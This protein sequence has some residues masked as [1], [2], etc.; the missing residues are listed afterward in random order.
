MPATVVEEPLGVA[1]VFSDGSRA[2]FGL[3]SLPAP[4]LARDLLV[5]LVELIHPHGSVD[6][7]GSVQH[8]VRAIRHMVRVVAGRGFAG[9]AG[10]LRRATLVE[11]W[12]GASGGK[13][14]C[15]RR[16]LH[17][18]DQ[19]TGGLAAPARELVAGRAYNPQPYRRALPPYPEAE[20]ARLTRTCQS[21][22]DAAF[23]AHR[24]ALADAATG[25]D[26]R[27]GGWSLRNLRWLLARTGP[28]STRALAQ[29]LGCSMQAIRERDGF[30]QAGAE[31]FPNL[32]NEDRAALRIEFFDETIEAIH[33]IDAI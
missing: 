23:A 15:T 18:F 20:W 24:D 7:A 13:E 8:Y 12:M 33:E 27:S 14:A 29:Q 17:G 26:P 25:Q 28:L 16:M 3:D 21:I 19:A 4:R 2:V 5:G 30:Y 11:Y 32:D 9:G 22:T 31:L 6:A 10:E 1:C